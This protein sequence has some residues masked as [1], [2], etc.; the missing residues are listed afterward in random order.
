MGQCRRSYRSVRSFLRSSY[1]QSSAAG[2]DVAGP[3]YSVV[4]LLGSLLAMMQCRG[5]TLEMNW[6]TW[7]TVCFKLYSKIDVAR[8]FMRVFV[9]NQDA[10]SACI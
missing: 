2:F 5:R 9:V 3:R 6:K 10:Q 4:L 1:Q 8:R 7:S